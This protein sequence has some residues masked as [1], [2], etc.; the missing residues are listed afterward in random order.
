MSNEL[1]RELDKINKLV[2]KLEDNVDRGMEA[3]SLKLMGVT[4]DE[5]SDKQKDR[6]RNIYGRLNDTIDE[7]MGDMHLFTDL[8]QPTKSSGPARLLS[9]LGMA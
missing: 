8:Y 3:I 6:L 9:E 5:L 2:E 1:D 4:C 7:M